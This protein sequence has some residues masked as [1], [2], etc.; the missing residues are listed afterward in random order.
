VIRSLAWRN[1]WRQPR[2]TIL[3]VLGIALPT[4]LLIFNISIHTATSVA[5]QTNSLRAFDGFA[6]VQPKGYLKDPDFR[7]AIPQPE[8]LATELRGIDG[9]SAVAPRMTTFAVLANGSRSYGASVVGVDPAREREVSTL[10]ATVHVGRFLKAS[11]S[12]AAV[13]GDGLARNLKLA[14]GDRVTLLGTAYDGSTAADVLRVVGIFHSGSDSFD[15]ETL[16]MP[17]A[18][19]QDTFGY[20]DRASIVAIAGS[21]LAGVED[22][23]PAVAR[24]AARHGVVVENWQVLE[25]SLYD[26]SVFDSLVLTMVYSAVVTV[27]VFI[28]LNTLLMSVLERTREFGVILALGMKPPLL[29]LVVWLELLLLTF[30]GIALGVA[31]G[32]GLILWFGHQ[33]IAVPG[34]E[35]MLTQLGL[36][37]RLYPALTLSGTFAVPGAILLAVCAAGLVPY[38]HVQRL[39]AASAAR[40]V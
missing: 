1:I 33:G 9:I 19:A 27:V 10:F 20:G 6:Q 14:V 22:A 17:L 3:T 30:V 31:I 36:P 38:L 12:S 16:E 13:I 5:T 40:G 25:P 37:Q 7:K 11:D 15:R 21:T 4:V 24:L 18:R 28:I 26:S 29:G 23:L 2:R 32:G 39:E 8:K 34:S 35:E